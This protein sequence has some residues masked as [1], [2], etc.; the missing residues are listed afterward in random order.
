MKAVI[1]TEEQYVAPDKTDWYIDQVV[2]EDRLLADALNALGWE[3][4]K[5]NWAN[6]AFD[7][8]SCDVAIFRSTW[9]YFHRFDEFKSWLDK[10]EGKTKFINP[11]EQIKWNMDK[12]YLLELEQK[13]IP[14]VES[15]FIETGNE[16]SLAQIH[17]ETGWD[18]TVLKPCVSGGGRHTFLLDPSNYDEH[19]AIFEEV[20][21]SESMILQP[22][23]K[24]ITKKGEVSLVV[25]NGQFTHAV[26]K[27]AKEGDYRVQDDFGGTVHEYQPSSEEIEF[28]ENV[29]K[30]CSPLPYY[31][32]ID[33][34]WDNNDALVISEVELIEPELWFRNNNL[35]A[36]KLAEAIDNNK[37]A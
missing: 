35:A 27:K 31:A 1:I 13:G 37:K 24:N 4:E 30:A 20:V 26:L 9:D 22:F 12:H 10:V 23:Q 32:R 14:V 11:I 6:P 29:T 25:I 18:K 7:W 33:V 19:E 15:L 2:L 17:E 5:V 34:I 16:K 8:S 28:A 36:N 3:C 21:S